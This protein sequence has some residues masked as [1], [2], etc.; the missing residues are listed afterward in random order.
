MFL[1]IS[2]Q[3]SVVSCQLSVV[4]CQFSVIN[5]LD[6]LAQLDYLERLEGL[7]MLVARGYRLS[8]D[9]EDD[10]DE[11]RHVAHI[12]LAVAIHIGS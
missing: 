4:S 10:V 5:F 3:L 7:E 8:V 9:I 6:S 12:H 2:Y 11:G 1:V